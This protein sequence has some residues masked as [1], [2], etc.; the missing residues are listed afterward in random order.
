MDAIENAA[1]VSVGRACGFAGLAVFCIMFGLSFEPILAARAGAVLCLALT[2]ILALY[3]Y[4][5]PARPYKRTELW[6]ILAKDQRPPAAFAQDVIGRTLRDTYAWFAKQTGIITAVL[7]V[8]S[9]VFRLL[10]IT[11]FWVGL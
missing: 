1:Y 9:V 4:H 8:V 3:A 6:L 5:A 2:A 7:W 11:E 10:G